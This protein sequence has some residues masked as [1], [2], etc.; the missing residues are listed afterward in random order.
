MI[1]EDPS[2]TDTCLPFGF[3]EL[4]PFCPNLEEFP[5]CEHILADINGNSALRLS[6]LFR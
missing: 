3:V 5:N 2:T 6:R 4:Y 1:D